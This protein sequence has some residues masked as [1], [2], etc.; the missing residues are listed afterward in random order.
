MK[1]IKQLVIIQII[2][3][4]V[5]SNLAYSAKLKKKDYLKNKVEKAVVLFDVNW[6]RKWACGQ[7]ENAQLTN[8]TFEKVDQKENKHNKY[9]IIELKTPSKLFAKPMFIHHGFIVDPGTYAFSGWAVKVAKSTSEVGYFKAKRSDLINGNA[10]IGGSFTVEDG[11]VIFIGSFFLD[12]Y[13]SPIPWRYY[14]DGKKSFEAQKDR[15]TKKFKFIDKDTI[16]FRLLNTT[17]FGQN[18]QLP[19]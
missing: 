19:E 3:T 5:F 8:L 12:C 18:Y 13:Q 1:S 9:S 6:G 15:M 14:P 4:L 2:G 11:E 17:N 16:K 10:Y 7:Y